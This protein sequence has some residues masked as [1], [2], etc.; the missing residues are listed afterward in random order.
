MVQASFFHGISFS[1]R[2][3]IL[4]FFFGGIHGL[5][6]SREPNQTT[7]AFAG[8][9]VT[10]S[11]NLILTPKEKTELLE[12]WFGTW[13]NNY[14]M[15]GTFLK[16]I[17]KTN[18]S[19][20]DATENTQ[21]AKRWHWNGDISRNYTIAYQLTN[22]QHDDAGDYGIRVR[23][24]TW[25]PGIESK[26]PFSLAIREPPVKP[27][28]DT[29]NLTREVIEGNR[30]NIT[31]R[32]IL[33]GNP[34]VV[35]K[36]NNIPLKES[37]NKYLVIQRVN[38]SQ[39]GNYACVSVA[40]SANQ[41]SAITTVDVL[42]SPSMRS[43]PKVTSLTVKKGT[44]V[45]LKCEADGNPQPIFT[46]HR[47]SDL[48]SSGFNSSRNVSILIVQYTG[49]E[50]FPRFVCTAKNR[51]GWDALTFYVQHARVTEPRTE[52]STEPTSRPLSAAQAVIGAFRTEEVDN[53]SRDVVL[54][55]S[56][57]GAVVLM[58]FCALLACMIY[59]RRSKT[60]ND[61]SHY[62]Q[63]TPRINDLV[64]INPTFSGDQEWEIP[65]GNLNIEKVIGRGAFGVVSRGLA[66][67]IPGRP[68]WTVVAVK[69]IQEDASEREKRDL[70]SE[71]AL[72]K[73]LDP[74]PHVIQL[75]GCIST[76]TSPLVVVEYAQYGDLLGYLRKSRGVH[77]NYYSDPSV[78]PRSTLTSKQLLKFAWEVSDG[79]EYLSMK[80]IIHRD[81]AA[82]N[83]LVGEDEVCKI[84]DFGMARDVQ[85]EDI[86]I[87]THEGRLPIKWTAP[88]AFFGGGAY[89]TASDVWSFG[90]VLYEIFT[91]GGDPFPGVYMRDIPALLESGYRMSRPKYVN[92]KLYKIMTGCWENESSQRPNF[93]FLRTTFHNLMEEENQ[94]YVNLEALLYE[95]VLPSKSKKVNSE[96][97]NENDSDVKTLHIEHD[98]TLVTKS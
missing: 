4:L 36:R 69:S 24:D 54:Y 83:V 59:K 48:V 57:S 16:K 87:R 25:P 72:L 65:R 12:V 76:E 43:K 70:L 80:K 5:T 6:I 91:V 29:R 2:F 56:I 19:I 52:K 89:T 86:Y 82:R 13:N 17:T 95:N 84:T 26:G 15:I 96:H 55:A 85:E 44:E 53:N 35:W 97:G 3:F 81:L 74:H 67:D 46:W 41:T 18:G 45:R 37:R 27:R 1:C 8:S 93:A 61:N 79:M 78:K 23:A 34:L 71:F 9:N 94:E 73:N 30:L 66:W 98:E 77:D 39:S 88:E 33:E 42:Y 51:V 32:L 62:G 58:V 63:N 75:F 14:Q 60:R 68:G 50:D 10:L 40:R 49:E 7:I 90:V 21:K 38:R 22:A 31:C 47:N 64:V 28:V 11:W 92:S 20:V